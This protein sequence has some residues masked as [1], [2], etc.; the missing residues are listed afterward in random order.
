V[1][2][3]VNTTLT[4]ALSGSVDLGFTL[5]NIA[6]SGQLG[7]TYTTPPGYVDPAMQFVDSKGN[8][9]G[10]SYKFTFQP[11]DSVITL[12][13]INP[14]T[15]AGQ[16]SLL[17]NTNLPQGGRSF[18]VPGN[19]AVVQSGSVQFTNVTSTAFDIEFV[20]VESSRQGFDATITFNPASGSEIKGQQVFHFNVN[21]VLE[22][23]FASDDGQRYGG[24]VSLTF[25]FQLEGPISAI[26]SATVTLDGSDP[27]TGNR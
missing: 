8:G 17:V 14:G 12:P 7:L 6:T 24:M 9:L 20:G 19:P 23:W 21:P 4:Q 22:Q 5:G 16:V 10:R 3:T 26:G 2:L 11:G 18:I 27:V 13:A 1:T 25:P 15:V